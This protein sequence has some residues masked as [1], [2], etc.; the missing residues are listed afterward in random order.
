KSPEF[1]NRSMVVRSRLLS[2][3]L[4]RWFRAQLSATCRFWIIT[5]TCSQM[6]IRIR[7]QTCWTICKSSRMSL[8][9][10]KL[11]PGTL[12]MKSA[13][14]FDAWL[15]LTSL[16]LALTLP[17]AAQNRRNNNQ[18]SPPP[19]PNRQEQRQQRREV[20]RPQNRPQQQ[21]QPRYE[22]PRPYQPPAQGHHSGQWLNQHREL[23][24]DQ[25]KKNLESDPQFRNLPRE[26]QQKL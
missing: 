20:P 8:Q 7:L 18:N 26:R 15:G 19:R 1:S 6:Q 25:Q 3:R 12:G 9:I 23:P 24:A 16:M 21:T 17:A 10:R 5:A 2:R 4:H 22:A 13:A 11:V 14:K